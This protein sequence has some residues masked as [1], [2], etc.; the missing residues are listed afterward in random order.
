MNEREKHELKIAW[1]KVIFV[2]MT[3]MVLLI[4]ALPWLAAIPFAVPLLLLAGFVATMILLK[5]MLDKIAPPDKTPH[6]DLPRDDR[7]LD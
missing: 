4:L 2:S 5:K 3:A 7:R 6:P 1:I